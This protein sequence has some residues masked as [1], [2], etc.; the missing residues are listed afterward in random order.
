MPLAAPIDSG[1]GVQSP[2]S[3]RILRERIT[4]VPVIVDAGVGTT[5]DAAVAE[6]APLPCREAL[7]WAGDFVA[8]TVGL[9][10]VH[11]VVVG[12]PPPQV[13]QVH[14]EKR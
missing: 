13:V 11:R 2:A 14:A 7:Y 10:R 3:L 1:L 8:L 9:H 6:P 5:S 12:R 4:E